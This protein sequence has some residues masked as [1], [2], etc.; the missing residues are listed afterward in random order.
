MFARVVCDVLLLFVLIYCCL[1]VWDEAEDHTLRQARRTPYL[2]TTKQ[3]KE[4][5]QPVDTTELFT[6]LSKARAT[7]QDVDRRGEAEATQVCF[8]FVVLF[9]FVLCLFY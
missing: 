4:E 5:P 2:L 9:V 3:R 7:R 6:S 1:K 8:L